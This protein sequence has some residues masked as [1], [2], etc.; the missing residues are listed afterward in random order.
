[1]S[2]LRR[3]PKGDNVSDKKSVSISVFGCLPFLLGVLLLA[4]LG[5]CG[6]GCQKDILGGV[7]AI[8]EAFAGDPAPAAPAV[9]GGQR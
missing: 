7:H 8:R 3:R 5:A 1:M 9:D 2:Y 4:G 6:K